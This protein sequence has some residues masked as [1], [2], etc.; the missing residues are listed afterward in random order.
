MEPKTS[1]WEIEYK[2]GVPD[3]TIAG[4][5][6][7]VVPETKLNLNE[8]KKTCEKNQRSLLQDKEVTVK[9]LTM[10]RII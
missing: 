8:V 7:L 5:S 6:S 10:T 9:I 2:F 4:M 3:K 1:Y